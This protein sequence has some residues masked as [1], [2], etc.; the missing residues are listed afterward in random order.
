MGCFS[1]DWRVSQC[2]VALHKRK[3]KSAPWQHITSQ[4]RMVN[5]L[6][7]VIPYIMGEWVQNCKTWKLFTMWGRCYWPQSYNVGCYHSSHNLQEIWRCEL[8]EPV[9][10]LLHLNLNNP[11]LLR[12]PFNTQLALLFQTLWPHE[13]PMNGALAGKQALQP[14]PLLSLCS[15]PTCR[16]NSTN[17]SLQQEIDRFLYEPIGCMEKFN[18]EL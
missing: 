16:C 15:A 10:E 8:T 9:Q 18:I 1:L 12:S 6:E 5:S 17:C 13:G 3:E 2:F 7:I 14:C 4:S 11:D